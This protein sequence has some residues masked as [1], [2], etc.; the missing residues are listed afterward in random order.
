MDGQ[1]QKYHS[2]CSFLIQN[3]EHL[4]PKAVT[5]LYSP[6]TVPAES[7][8][9]SLER[10]HMPMSTPSSSYMQHRRPKMPPPRP[11]WSPFGPTSSHLDPGL[12]ADVRIAAAFSV[13]IYFVMERTWAAIGADFVPTKGR[14]G[15]EERHL[16]K[17]GTDQRA[18]CPPMSEL[19]HVSHS[20]SPLSSDTKKH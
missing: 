18:H 2:R 13:R 7:H 1:N 9:A 4:H 6:S 20:E 14:L 17:A 5:S 15:P 19:V 8:F 10:F 11:I 12:S 3:R 16:R